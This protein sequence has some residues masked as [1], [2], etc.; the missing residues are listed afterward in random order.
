MKRL[1]LV[2][3]MLLLAMGLAAPALSAKQADRR[4][5]PGGHTGPVKLQTASAP[6]APKVSGRRASATAKLHRR[7]G[8]LVPNQ[9]AYQRAKA[10]ATARAGGASTGGSSSKAT[11]P[12]TGASADSAPLIASGDPDIYPAWTGINDPNVAPPDSTGAIGPS[13]YVELVNDRF[14]IFDRSG[15]VLSAGGLQTLVGAGTDCVTDP[16]IIWDPG[17]NRF[18][19]VVLDFSHAEFFNCSNPSPANGLY[20]GFSRTSSPS[21]G[22]PSS[23]CTY[24]LPYFQNLPD[25]DA[26][27]DYPKLGDTSAFLLI[28]SNLFDPGYIGSDVA[29]VTKPGPGTSCPDLFANHLPNPLLDSDGAPA[30]TPVPANQTDTSGTGYVAAAS[31]PFASTG[32]FLDTYPVSTNF[33]N[34]IGLPV[35]HNVPAYNLPANAPQSGTP[36]LLDTLD[37]RLTQAVSGFDPSKNRIA[38]WTQHTVAG[39]AGSEVRWYEIDPPVTAQLLRSGVVSDASLYAFNAAI[40]PDRKVSGAIRSFGDAF[41]LG[42]NTSSASDFV[43]IQMVSQWAGNATS[44]WVEVKASPGFN[45][46][47][48]CTPGVCRWGD[49]SGA[50]PDPAANPYS[51]HG[52]VW[53]SNQ[54]NVA[55]IDTDDVDW[56]TYNWGTNPAPYVVLNAP[57]TLFQKGTSFTVSWFLGNQASLADVR[58]R[59]AP[60]NGNFGGHNV[61]KSKV[62]AGSAGFPG[63]AGR[64][65]CLSAQ[66]YD[67]TDIGPRLWGFGGERCTVVPLDDRSLTRSAGWSWGTGGGFFKNTF[68]RATGLGKSL[69]RTG[70]KAKRIQVMVMKCPTCGSIRIYWKGVL[71]R[72]YNLR[73]GRVLKKVYLNVA[74]FGS[75]E[76]GTL[77][78]VVSSSGKPVIIDAVGISLV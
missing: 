70:V 12:R 51:N 37:G 31:D 58:F 22:S 76:T 60:W 21:S 3:G 78:I 54:W 38:V 34:P 26:L 75:V 68:S 15:N 71:R 55:S 62:P 50:T 47:F 49:Y 53:L 27:P 1:P 23:W 6:S 8:Y 74:T 44:Q 36:A 65:Y 30:F 42:F 43:R 73:A 19:Y 41:V 14:G 20:I 5:W 57:T 32:D 67:D 61:W 33:A 66:S 48:T 40:S 52:R 11:A 2:A 7:Q 10:A 16:Q 39:G 46:D 45:D 59:A 35:R 29:W 77:K 28:G 56:R 64:T 63:T 17:T 25:F 24:F 69:T 72:S 18:Y 13:R 4:T 9:A